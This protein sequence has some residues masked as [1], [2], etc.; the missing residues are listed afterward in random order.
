MLKAAKTVAA[1]RADTLSVSDA[2]HGPFSVEDY[3]NV[4]AEA[5]DYIRFINA[6]DYSVVVS[7]IDLILSAPPIFLPS[8]PSP[9]QHLRGDPLRKALEEIASFREKDGSDIATI[10]WNRAGCYARE[11]AERA[12]ASPSS[13]QSKPEVWRDGLGRITPKPEHADAVLEDLGYDPTPSP[14]VPAFYVSRMP[15]FKNGP[16][17]GLA[18]L[19]NPSRLGSFPAYAAPQQQ[20][21][22]LP[23]DVINLVIAAREFW[24]LAMD[25]SDESASLD[26]ALEAFSSRVPYD[27][28]P[29]VVPS[30]SPHLRGEE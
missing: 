19:Q 13:P 24:E 25:D 23:Q 11:V 20:T 29:D 8:D 30:T 4:L 5:K 12:L 10:E 1:R 14:Q 6:S 16:A 9:S 22:G 3:R 27:N 21:D 28:E 7:H 18:A 17:E 26:A 2:L 15:D